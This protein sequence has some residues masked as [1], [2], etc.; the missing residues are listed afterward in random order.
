LALVSN[1]VGPRAWL[2]DMAVGGE[3]QAW[4]AGGFAAYIPGAR[5]RSKSYIG[6]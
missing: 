5:Y 6:Q 2:D 3:P 4:S 1:Q